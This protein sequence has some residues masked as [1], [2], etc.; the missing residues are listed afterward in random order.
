MVCGVHGPGGVYQ[1]L[2]VLPQISVSIGSG[3]GV[4]PLGSKSFQLTVTLDNEQQSAAD[5]ELH[6]QLPDGWTAEPAAEK[7]HLPANDPD[8]VTFTIHPT[9]LTDASYTIKAV[10]RSGSWPGR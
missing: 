5:G 8:T 3:A 9:S 1:P 4:V 2:V 10:A 7:F 6:L